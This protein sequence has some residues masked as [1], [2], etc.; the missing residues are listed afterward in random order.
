MQR[1]GVRAVSQPHLDVPSIPKPHTVDL[2]PRHCCPLALAAVPGQEEVGSGLHRRADM[3][4]IGCPQ[5]RAFE[6]HQRF[7]HYGRRQLHLSAPDAGGAAHSTQREAPT[8]R[9]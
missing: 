9:A 2:H 6:A 1:I 3:E 4:R 8:S 7:V 5:A